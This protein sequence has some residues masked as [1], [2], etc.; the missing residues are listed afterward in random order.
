ML[1]ARLIDGLIR[2]QNVLEAGALG[3]GELTLPAVKLACVERP[4]KILAGSI[5]RLSPIPIFC[6]LRLLSESDRPSSESM[7]DVEPW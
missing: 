7:G 5:R 6:G 4:T 3:F 2:V 1:V